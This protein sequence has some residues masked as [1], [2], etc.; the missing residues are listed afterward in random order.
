MPLN[1]EKPIIPKIPIASKIRSI[2]F[3][4]L[5]FINPNALFGVFLL[6]AIIIA[7]LQIPAILFHI[8]FSIFVIGYFTER[9]FLLLQKKSK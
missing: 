5:S 3:Q 8:V 4:S 7:F 6:V 9:I 2:V 1:Y